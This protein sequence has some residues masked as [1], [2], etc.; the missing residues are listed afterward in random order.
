MT[1]EHGP[2]RAKLRQSPEPNLPR[3]T[4]GTT[5]PE[6]LWLWPECHDDG[7]DKAV[8]FP[9]QPYPSGSTEYIRADLATPAPVGREFGAEL[10]GNT[11]GLIDKMAEAIRGDTTSDD[12]PWAVLPE[13]RKIGW[14]GD[15]ERALAAVKEYLTAHSPA[16]VVPAE[17]LAVERVEMVD[18]SSG[19]AEPAD[20]IWRIVI[21]G[22]CADFPSEAAARNFAAQITALRSAPPVGARVTGWQ[23]IGTAPSGVSRNGKLG[24]CWMMLAIPHDDGGYNCVSGM[25]VGDKFFACLT[26]YC[27]G[28]FD[29]KQ[30]VQREV[31]VL[32]TH[33]MPPPEPPAALLPAGEGE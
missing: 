21:N 8:S 27:G 29:G 10:S 13:D 11:G 1:N 14:R 15:A 18:W 5:R 9:D 4:A 23:P 24:V 26:F 16:P 7:M 31:E 6:R 19:S 28:P 32:P 2:N 22:Q 20:P 30:Y 25:R 17:G 12:T 33:W 3:D